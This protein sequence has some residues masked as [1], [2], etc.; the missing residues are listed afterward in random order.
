MVMKRNEILDII[1]RRRA[2]ETREDKKRIAAEL[3][4]HKAEFFERGGKITKVVSS[5]AASAFDSDPI[6]PV[7]NVAPVYHD[8]AVAASVGYGYAKYAVSR[9]R[10]IQKAKQRKKGAPRAEEGQPGGQGCDEVT[11]ESRQRRTTR[12]DSAPLSSDQY[13]LSNEEE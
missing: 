7:E 4:Q 11:A 6:V 12:S 5:T 3:E 8:P 10:A 13:L 9:E 2:Q 1:T